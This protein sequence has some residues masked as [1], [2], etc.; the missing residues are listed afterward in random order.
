MLTLFGGFA[1]L[2]SHST[3]KKILKLS[4]IIVLI[5]GVIMINRGLTVLGSPYSYDAIK[6]NIAGVSSISSSSVVLN[7]GVQEI[8]MTVDRD[9]WSP[10]TFVLKKGVPAVWKI[11][12]EQL[13]GCNNEI[14]VRDY[15]LDIVLKEGLNEVEFTPD[16]TGTIR[17]SCWMGM[18]PGSFIVTDDGFASESEVDA[19]QP[20]ASGSCGGG[21]TCGG[22]G[23]CG[24]GCGGGCGG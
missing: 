21:S 10:D 22:T 15:G 6:Q 9:G 13:T 7:N 24:G 11:N 12:V 18:I 20:I 17:W 4:A 8:Y 2:V 23:S 3:T 1:T 5:L 14:I 19:A 16:E